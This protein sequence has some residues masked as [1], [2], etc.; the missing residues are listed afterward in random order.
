MSRS[1]RDIATHL[2]M[3]RPSGRSRPGALLYRRRA[4][5]GP[6]AGNEIRLASLAEE[7]SREL[8]VVDLKGGLYRIVDR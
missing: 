1:F 2:P 4:L 6:N 7:L 8:Y 5:H 3:P